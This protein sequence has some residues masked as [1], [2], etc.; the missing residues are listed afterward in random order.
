MILLR[1]PETNYFKFTKHLAYI[2][3]FELVYII[4]C[5]FDSGDLGVRAGDGILDNNL[6]WRNNLL[7]CRRGRLSAYTGVS[8]GLLATLLVPCGMIEC[9]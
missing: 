2:I 3:H 1:P 6:H 5:M 8:F 7:S 4:G 9:T